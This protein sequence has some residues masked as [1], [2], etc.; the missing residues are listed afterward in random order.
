M[1]KWKN[2]K[3]EKKKNVKKQNNWLYRLQKNK[4]NYK[5]AIRHNPRSLFVLSNG[6]IIASLSR[7]DGKTI[8]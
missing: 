8:Y 1:K 5:I 3:K 7:S 6:R 4:T 2:E